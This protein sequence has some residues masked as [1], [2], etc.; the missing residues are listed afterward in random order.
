MDRTNI[1]CEIGRWA[2]HTQCDMF[3]EASYD[4]LRGEHSVLSSFWL[5]NAD[6]LL[7]SAR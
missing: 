4:K 6:M 3:S 1:R 7:Q 5:T 2:N